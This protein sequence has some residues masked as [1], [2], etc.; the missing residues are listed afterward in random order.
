VLDAASFLTPFLPPIPSCSLK[1]T[2]AV[3][4]ATAIAGQ[5]PTGEQSQEAT[6]LETQPLLLAVEGEEA[7]SLKTQQLEEELELLRKQ[8][9]EGEAHFRGERDVVL[10]RLRAKLLQQKNGTHVVQPIVSSPRLSH[11][12]TRACS[13]GQVGQPLSF[14]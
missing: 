7:T 8:L 12:L 4:Q 11:V 6:S 13:C 1:D 10:S 5:A 14:S 2:V 9:Q 3:H